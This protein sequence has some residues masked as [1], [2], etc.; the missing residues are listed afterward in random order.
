MSPTKMSR[1]FSI[2][3]CVT[4]VPMTAAARANEA[5]EASSFKAMP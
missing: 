5:I 2:A 3:R 1:K 4:T